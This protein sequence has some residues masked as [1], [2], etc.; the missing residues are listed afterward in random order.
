MVEKCSFRLTK[1]STVAYYALKAWCRANRVPLGRILNAALQ[2]LPTLPY[3]DQLNG[4][5]HAAIDIQYPRQMDIDDQ[6]R[7]RRRHK[8]L[9]RVKV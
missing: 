6:L 7:Y 5:R 9:T 4:S 8:N 2:A 3:Y 1:E